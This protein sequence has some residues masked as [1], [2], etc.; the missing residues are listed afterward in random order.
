MQPGGHIACVLPK[1][2]KTKRVEAKHNQHTFVLTSG[3]MAA[4]VVTVVCDS[5]TR[6]CY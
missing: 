4:R 1:K 2:R 5:N 6:V 3:E